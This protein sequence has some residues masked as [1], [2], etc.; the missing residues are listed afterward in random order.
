MKQYHDLL[1]HVLDNGVEKSDRTGT[2]TKSVFGYQMRFN[3]QDG[4]P[5][6][7]T[8]RMHM[9]S[10]VHELIFFLSG[11]TNIKYL[12]DNN[13]TIW[14]S[15]SKPDGELGPGIYGHS[16]RSWPNPDGTSVDQISK[17]IDSIKNNPDSRRHL[18]VAYNPTY[19]DTV[20]LPPC[21]SMFQFYVTNGK[22][23]CQLYQRSCDLFLGCGFNIASY[24]ILTHMI[25]QSCNL[26]VGEFIHTIGDA[27]IYLNHMDQVALL[28]SREERALPKLELNPEIKSVF[29]FKF[30]DIKVVGY[31]PHPT[32]K[33]EVAV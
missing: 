27:H 8:K 11:S 1:K 30:E 4:F 28:L 17:V 33:A 18:V 6:I 19:S 9:K 16:W 12:Q 24:A 20:V 2:G 14:D 29:D 21:H 10:I 23:S 22:L 13:V 32:I 5:L 3:L 31:D 25:A 15:W 7:T 26:E